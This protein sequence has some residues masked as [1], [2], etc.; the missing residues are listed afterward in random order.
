E[1]DADDDDDDDDDDEEEDIEAVFPPVSFLV[2]CPFSNCPDDTLPL[3]QPSQLTNHL[4][5]CH[6]LVFKNIQHMV[7]S[8]QKYLD[9]WAE[10]LQAAEADPATLPAGVATTTSTT[11]V[12]TAGSNYLIDAS[13][14]P[15]D[16]ELRTDLQK[17][18]LNEI[19]QTQARERQTDSPQSRKCLFCKQMCENRYRLFRHMFTEHNFNIGLPDNLVDVNEFLTILET[20]L[21]ELQCL[22]C[23]KTFTS[24]AVLRKHMRKKKH[25]KISARNR[26]YDRFYIVNFLEPGKNWENFENEVY[27]SGH[28]NAN[29]ND[30]DE[31]G[32]GWGDWQEDDTSPE[33]TMCLFDNT[34]AASPADACDHMREAH[35]FDLPAL[36]R[37]RGLDFYQTIRLINF[38]R[39][40]TGRGVC[41]AC[42]TEV[43]GAGPEGSSDSITP[44][45]KHMAENGCFTSL[46]AADHPFWEDVQYLFPTYENDPLLMWFDDSWS[47]EEAEEAAAEVET[48]PKEYKAVQ[49]DV[50][51]EK[52]IETLAQATI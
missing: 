8:L 14:C 22:Y 3:T 32:E 20:K 2:L 43:A 34:V 17:G 44:L 18:K 15:A 29:L 36:R 19:L 39:R 26:L 46:P 16:L 25:F 33:N 21:A 5:D 52:V 10:K 1:N 12:V 11:T 51:L 30:D 13:Q 6:G 50:P 48:E 37:A 4:N 41:M 28:L 27:D 35:G 9:S 24:T 31:D 23:E 47:D 49:A 45:A 7:F 38:I 40:Q 42:D